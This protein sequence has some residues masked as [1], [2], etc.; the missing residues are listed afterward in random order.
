VAIEVTGVTARSVAAVAAASAR[1]AAAPSDKGRARYWDVS[2][3]RRYVTDRDKL[4]P[5]RKVGTCAN[6][7]APSRWPWR[8][9]QS[10]CSRTPP[11]TTASPACW[12]ANSSGRR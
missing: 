1:A 4:E 10:R 12:A 6:T 11:S 9:R 3:L 2:M 7:S 8:A 5:R